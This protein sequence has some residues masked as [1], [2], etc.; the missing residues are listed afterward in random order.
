MKRVFWAEKEVPTASHWLKVLRGQ[1]DRG[2]AGEEE[3][4]FS[5]CLRPGPVRRAQG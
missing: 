4:C 5:D 3:G 1:G 2:W